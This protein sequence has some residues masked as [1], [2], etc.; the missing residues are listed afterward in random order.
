WI[1]VMEWKRQQ[2]A[3][4]A[5]DQISRGDRIELERQIAM[6]EWHAFGR[7]G[8]SRGI[9]QDRAV[10]WR[11]GNCWLVWFVKQILP[12]TGAFCAVSKQNEFA[13]PAAD[14]LLHS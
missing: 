13:V 5:G 6:R 1:D 9:K 4:V 10:F 14:G 7:P 11:H 12:A 8:C 3:I 2:D